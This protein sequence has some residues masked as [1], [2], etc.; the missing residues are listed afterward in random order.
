[1]FVVAPAPAEGGECPR[2]RVPLT[3]RAVR[4]PGWRVL[5][6]GDC[7]SCGHHYLQELPT[8][9]G[10]YYPSTL[11]LTT[12]ESLGQWFETE[13]FE[14]FHAP[15]EA[16]LDVEVRRPDE[17]RS[18]EAIVLDCLDPVYGHALLKLLNAQRHL[19]HDAGR[20]LIVAVPA[21]LETLLPDG[22]AE[23]WVVGGPLARQRGWL[24]AFEALVAERLAGYE[25]VLLSTALPH[26][27]PSTFDIERFTGPLVPERSGN[28]SVV[29][30]L[31]PDRFWGRGAAA[32]RDNVAELAA[33]LRARLPEVGISVIGTV[34]GDL[35]PPGVRDLT[36]PRP[37]PD[38]ERRWMAVAKGADLAF[39]VHG[40]NMLLPSALARASL[41]LLPESRFANATQATLLTERDPVVATFAHRVV[42]GDD[43]LTDV[44]PGRVA[45]VALPLLEGFD[46]VVGFLTGRMAGVG[47]DGPDR[48][49]P[50]QRLAWEPRTLPV[51]PAG[52]RL[53]WRRR[54]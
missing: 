22:I 30:S 52:S 28:P 46:R 35:V 13:L 17:Q 43:E 34:E 53:P 31:R 25:R 39:G 26:P 49:P 44:T 48:W 4:W 38:V 47:G 40:S 51:E 8:G 41:E 14:A 18:T 7:P 12:S 37:S 21:A 24:T 36:D 11:D 29:V 27:H 32:Q 45:A 10:V 33:A 20:D 3:V 2:C 19:D 42:H 6:D 5:L 9:H 50:E 1:M 23:A 54:R 16:P 15:D